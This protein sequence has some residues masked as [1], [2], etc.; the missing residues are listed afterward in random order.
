MFPLFRT[1][2]SLLGG[3]ITNCLIDMSGNR[4]TN[5]GVPSHSQDAVPKSY[6]DNLITTYSINLQASMRTYLTTRKHGAFVV[7]I[8]SV[9]AGGPCAVFAIAKAVPELTVRG[10]R[11]SSSQ[12]N[13][14]ETVE[15]EWSSGGDLYIYKTDNATDGSFLVKV[16]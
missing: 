16:I 4:I 15:I 14:G 1:T 2:A 9:K 6:V 7:S 12:G 5:L 3:S 11:I 8:T 10:N 13:G